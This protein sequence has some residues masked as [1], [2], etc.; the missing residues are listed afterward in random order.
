MK[1]GRCSCGLKALRMICDPAR[2]LRAYRHDDSGSL[3]VFG[4]FSMVIILILAGIG[5]DLVRH[6]TL[7]TELQ[8]TLDRAVLAATNLDNTLAPED[9]VRDYFT[10]AGLIQYLNGVNVDA[11]EQGREVTAYVKATVP[12][13]FMRFAGVDTLALASSGTAV[14]GTANLEISL[15]LDVSGSMNR[16]SRIDNLAIAGQQFAD[17][18]FSNSI[19]GSVS[20]SVVPYSTQVNAGS[21]I[22]SQFN[23][24]GRHDYSYC[25]NFGADDFKTTALDYD[26]L[27]QQTLSFDPWYNNGYNEGTVLEVCDPDAVN[28][29]LPLSNSLNAIKSK[30]SGLEADGNTSIDLGVKWGAALLDPSAKQ[31]TAALVTS[32]EVAGELSDRPYNPATAD[33][34]TLKVM[35]VMTDGV[36]TTQYYMPSDYRSGYSDMYLAP[37]GKVS[38]PTRKRSCDYYSCWYE[39]K[40]YIPETGSYTNDVYGGNDAVRLTWPEVWRRFTVTSHAY[41]RYYASGSSSDYYFWNDATRVGV[42]NTAKNSRLLEICSAA[43]SNGVLLFTIGFEAPWDAAEVLKSCASSAAHYYD[44]DG[45]EIADAFSAIATKVTQLRLVE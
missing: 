34:T 11:V 25:I 38:F 22:L 36:N 5:V 8:N 24:T 41:A 33:V 31:L 17:T 13:Y 2:A 7:R 12:T 4:I 29:V 39:D 10:K 19:P 9:V 16:S 18:I 15:V 14:Q 21:T 6:E 32:G 35:V 30:I 45:L 27:Y 23:L 44:V 26:S 42:G 40:W 20:V 1:P 37:D 28:T 3:T 43:K